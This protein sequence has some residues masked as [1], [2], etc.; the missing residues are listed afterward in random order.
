MWV[1][2]LALL[3]GLKIRRVAVNCG[4]GSRHSWDVALLRLWRRPAAVA[5]IGPLAWEPPY[6]ASVALK[7]KKQTNKREVVSY[8]N[9]NK[10]LFLIVRF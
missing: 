10:A 4:V 6:V 5:L 8:L 3:S 2:S 9:L 1:Q 7:R